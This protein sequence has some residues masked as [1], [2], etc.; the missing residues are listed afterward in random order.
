M[1]NPAATPEHGIFSRSRQQDSRNQPIS[2]A[3]SAVVL[4][5]PAQAL[6]AGLQSAPFW[7]LAG[8]SVTLNTKSRSIS[9]QLRREELAMPV[10]MKAK[11]AQTLYELLKHKSLD[12][13]TVKE[14]VDTCNISRQ[15]FYYH[16]QDIMDVVEWCQ[17]QSLKQSIERSLEAPSYKE[18]IRGLIYE[19]FEHRV[20]I[21][22]LMAS[23][24]RSEMERLFLKAIRTYLQAL[25]RSKGSRISCSQEDLETVLSFCS[26][27]LVGILLTSLSQKTPD[28]DALA[29]QMCRLL[30]GEI[31]FCFTDP[32]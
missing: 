15:S 20:L 29:N 23:Q 16:F 3:A 30:T 18:A 25:H 27:G 22:Q 11:I 14:L 6:S 10:D 17:N 32:A 1:P 13:I 5:H 12:K 24:R 26:C 9:T 19:T 2:S 7:T 21:Q 28:V 31:T 8:I 4:L